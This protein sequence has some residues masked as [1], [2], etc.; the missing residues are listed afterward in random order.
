MALVSSETGFS[1]D[2]NASKIYISSTVSR[3]ILEQTNWN[4]S[5]LAAENLSD[6]LLKTK[7]FLERIGA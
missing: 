4:P 3:T 6:C 2:K 7:I 5:E 1:G